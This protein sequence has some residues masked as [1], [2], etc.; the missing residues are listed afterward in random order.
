MKNV[1]QKTNR[2]GFTLIEVIAVMAIVTVILG[3]V[4]AAVQGAMNN[5]KVASTLSTIKA[6]QTASVNFYN[7]NGGTYANSGSLG[8][9][10]SLA[11][12]AAQNMLPNNVINGTNAW[13]GTITI[14]PDTNPLYFDL[15][16]TN[17]PVNAGGTGTPPGTLT[18][19]VANLIQATPTYTA[20]TSTWTAVF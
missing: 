6:L 10:L 12:L 1:R 7:A 4:L 16:L 18:A 11:N 5:G 19:A 20:K 2:N 13:N 3:A 9:G 8:V 15:T 17:V 14:A